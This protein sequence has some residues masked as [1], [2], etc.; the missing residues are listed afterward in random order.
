MLGRSVHN[1]LANIISPYG[2]PGFRF[3]IKLIDVER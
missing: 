2:T 1:H 3:D